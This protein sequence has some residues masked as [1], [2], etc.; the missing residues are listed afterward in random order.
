[1]VN[2]TAAICTMLKDGRRQIS[3]IERSGD[4]ICGPMAAPETPIWLEALEPATVCELDFE[5]NAAALRQDPG[6]LMAMFGVV[7]KRLEDASRHLT[8]LGR[9]DSTERLIHFLADNAIR[10]G[11]RQPVRLPMSREDIADYLG[12]NAET[13]SRIFSRV[14]KTGLFAF[15]SP[16]DYVVPNLEAIR[17]RL[18][19]PLAKPVG[20]PMANIAGQETGDMEKAG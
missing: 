19:V 16:T 20:N 3:G 2:G 12:L 11:N 9:L 17:R 1:V 15:S 18:P 6:F 10:S 14:R 7:H 13:V 4:T 8:T 5:N